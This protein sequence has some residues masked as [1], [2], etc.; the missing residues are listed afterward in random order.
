MIVKVQ[1]AIFPLGGPALVYDE[2]RLHIVQVR[3]PPTVVRT[4]GR[5]KKA[6]FNATWT[7]GE[8]I[9]LARAAEQSW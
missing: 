6:Y 8:W 2:A 3:L 7:G 4:M 1:L 5:N 9:I